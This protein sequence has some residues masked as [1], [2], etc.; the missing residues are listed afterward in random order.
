[1]SW[2]ERLLVVRSLSHLQRE[3]DQLHARLRKAEAALARLTPPRALKD[4]ERVKELMKTPGAATPQA[5]APA[6]ETN[7]TAL[8]QQ[9]E[10][11]LK[12][13]KAALRD[14]LR[15]LSALDFD[16]LLLCD[17]APILEGGRA[18]LRRTTRRR[19]RPARSSLG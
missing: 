14:S 4:F 9:S 2:E 18:A 7:A 8:V 10:A 1:V 11:R 12:R 19:T 16:S 6:A 17:G 15:R 3:T 13:D 5:G